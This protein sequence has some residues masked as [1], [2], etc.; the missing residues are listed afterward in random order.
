MSNIEFTRDLFGYI[1]EIKGQINCL[2]HDAWLAEFGY[3]YTP[4]ELEQFYYWEIN[5][6]EQTLYETELFFGLI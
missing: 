2:K 5:E 1:D 3:Y 4:S 6:L